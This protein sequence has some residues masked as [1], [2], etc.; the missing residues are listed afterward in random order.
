MSK[1][2]ILCIGM[3]SNLGGIETY[4]YNLVKN[5][6]K[7]QF[8]IH[9]LEA[10]DGEMPLKKEIEELGVIIHKIVPRNKD[11]K[12]H[13]RQ[14][15][16]VYIHD[17]FDYVHYGLMSFSWFEPIVLAKKYSNAK[18]IIHSHSGGFSKNVSLKTKILHEI[19]KFKVRNINFYRVA[20][21]EQAGKWMFGGHDFEIFY[22]GI[23]IEKFS[24]NQ[25]YREEIRKKY[26][27][28][29]SSTVMGLVG[30]LEEV[31][32]HDF[33]LDIFYEYKKR[34]PNA[35]L[36]LVGEGSLRTQFENRAREQNILENVIFAGKILDC[37]KIYS[38]FDVFVMPSFSEG[39]SIALV[40]AQINGL[41]CYTSDGVDKKSNITGNVQ[42]LSLKQ[43]ASEWAQYIF[44]TNNVRDKEILSKVPDK[45]DDKKSYEKVYQFYIDKIAER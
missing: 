31:K 22:N 33:L 18:I 14:L 28:T 35:K 5:A 37:Y 25:E 3:S 43:S 44:N 27:I 9:F 45:F 19:G 24:F 23:D 38:A 17:E 10:C 30:K 29:E 7:E 26:N 11:Y 42:F 4:L 13:L 8:E 12:E 16:E 2:K 41:K 21:G 34:N 40:E 6:N 32:N 20:C 15:E 39:F 1:I 36:L